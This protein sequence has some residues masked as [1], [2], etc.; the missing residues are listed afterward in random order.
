MCI[1]WEQTKE[2][3]G[4]Q[5]WQAVIDAINSGNQILAAEHIDALIEYRI[6]PNTCP[7]TIDGLIGLKSLLEDN[8]G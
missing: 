6:I 3:T 8:N 1:I 4:F 7:F 2:P 5:L